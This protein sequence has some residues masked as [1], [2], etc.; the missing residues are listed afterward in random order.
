MIMLISETANVIS[1][2]NTVENGIIEISIADIVYFFP[3]FV[4]DSFKP[5]CVL[6]NNHFQFQALYG[7]R[8]FRKNQFK[9]VLHLFSATF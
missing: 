4:T 6:V 1:K 9:A 5:I 7:K 2:I 3:R 8:F